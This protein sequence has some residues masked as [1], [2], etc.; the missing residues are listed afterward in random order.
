MMKSNTSHDESTG[1]LIML[2]DWHHKKPSSVQAVHVICGDWNLHI[3]TWKEVVIIS[4]QA[5]H[6]EKLGQWDKNFH[7]LH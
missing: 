3:I 5:A 4:S 6:L 2:A 7:S 1:R